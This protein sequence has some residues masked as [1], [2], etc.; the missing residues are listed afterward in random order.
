MLK[1]KQIQLKERLIKVIDDIGRNSYADNIRQGVIHEFKSRNLSASRASFAMTQNLDLN[2]LNQSDDEDIRFLFFLTDAINKSA[3]G[4]ENI[5]INVEDYFTKFEVEKWSKYKETN[6]QDNIYPIVLEDVTE[7][8]DRMWQLPLTAQRLNRL[9]VANILLYNFR[10]QRNPKITVSGEKIN[11]DTKEVQEIKEN[12]LNGNQYP[13]QIRLN[14]LNTGEVRPIYNSKNRTLT[15]NEGCIINI[16]D[17]YHRKTA[18]DL[19]LAEN[20]SLDFTWSIMVTY[21]SEKQ[22]HDFMTQI[23]KQKPI[24][25]EFIQQMDYTKPENLVVDIIMDDKLSELAQVTKDADD[26]IRIN[27][28]LTKKSIIAEAIADNYG[29]QIKTSIG[30]R[31]VGKWIVEFTDQL[32][33]LYVEEFITN[34]YEIKEKSIINHKNMFYG[35]IALSAELQNNKDWKT[36]LK[37][38]MDSIDFN[39]SNPMWKDIGIIGNKDANKSTRKKIYRLFKEGISQCAI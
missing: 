17:G 24:K 7:L 11:M 25:K 32:M 2:T 1:E 38:T 10:T 16:F 39:I 28:A 21:L 5:K 20:E 4:K 22:A 37:A 36:L 35:Y 15:L 31:N 33:G 9:S 34:P 27:R 3:E 18:N 19:A 30:V 23:N 14:V 6:Q 8:N 29:D 13:D 26:Y 12:L